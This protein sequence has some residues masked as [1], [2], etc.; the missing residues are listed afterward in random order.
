G[1]GPRVRAARQEGCRW[2]RLGGAREGDPRRGGPDDREPVGVVCE[3]AQPRRVELVWL[4]TPPDPVVVPAEHHRD[5]VLVDA[6]EVDAIVTEPLQA[7]VPVDARVEDLE[8]V[9]RRA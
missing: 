6:G 9:A 1:R 3:V 7:R 4:R 5:D 2:W 8:P